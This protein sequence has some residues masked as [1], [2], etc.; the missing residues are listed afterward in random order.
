MNKTGWIICAIVFV[1]VTTFVLSLD[2]QSVKRVKFSNRDIKLGHEATEFSNEKDSIKINLEQSKFDNKI[3]ATNKGVDINSSGGVSDSS[4]EYTNSDFDYNNQS[5]DFS[6]GKNNIKYKNIDD[7]QLDNVLNEA[8][9]IG[10]QRNEGSK[11]EP[12]YMYKNIDWSTWHSNFVNKILDDSLYIHELD[13][14]NEGA[15][16]SY[17]FDVYEDGS[18]SNISVFSMF[19]SPADKDRIISLIKGYQYKE[20]TVFPANSKRKKAKVSAVMLLSDST[21]KSNPSDFQ[22]T[23]RIQIKYG[24]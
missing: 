7:T 17:S 13:N 23:E 20:I 21:K 14:Y 24:N 18:I 3:S 5:S 4:I 6:S 11:R 19:L 8:R 2:N 15:W 10:Q 9:N 16:F 22:D 1:F 12:R